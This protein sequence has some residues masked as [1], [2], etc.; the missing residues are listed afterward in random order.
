LINLSGG[1]LKLLQVS[2]SQKRRLADQFVKKLSAT[3]NLE[4][5]L[6]EASK[7]SKKLAFEPMA[8]T[9]TLQFT[10]PAIS[11]TSRKDQPSVFN[12]FCNRQGILIT[13]RRCK[14]HGIPVS[15]RNLR[16]CP[17]L[18]SLANGYKPFLSDS[19]QKAVICTTL[20]ARQSTL[21]KRNASKLKT[22][23]P[24][25][26]VEPKVSDLPVIPDIS[27]LHHKAAPHL[28]V[29]MLHALGTNLCGI[30]PEEL[31]D[32]QLLNLDVI[33]EDID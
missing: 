15:A 13:Y 30:P 33:I 8:I 25:T 28:P 32:E 2:T 16:R 18:S 24:A 17:R 29:E 21:F 19:K 7:I 3:V 6:S 11:D 12:R 4:S 22:P 10:S 1:P 27:P 5:H 23:K 20:N 9:G 14:R 26:S 31:A